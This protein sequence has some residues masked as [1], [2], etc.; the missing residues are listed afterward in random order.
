MQKNTLPYKLRF[1]FSYSC[2]YI[3]YNIFKIIFVKGQ[4]MATTLR[5]KQIVLVSKYSREYRENDII[6]FSVD[7]ENRIKRIIATKGDVVSLKNGFLW[8]NGI[9]YEAYTCDVNLSK[10]YRLKKNE[11]FVVGDNYNA[12]IDSRN[13]GPILREN[14]LGKVILY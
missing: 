9:K 3:I 5:D 13:H 1:N 7:D 6:V 12:S 8:I 14:I 4:S 10:E 11:Y 2:F